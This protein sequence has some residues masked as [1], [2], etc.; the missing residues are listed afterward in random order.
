[1]LERL[2]QAA[3]I[4]FLLHLI[5]GLNAGNQIPPKS[6]SPLSEMPTPVLGSTIRLF[7]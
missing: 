2:I 1:M 3:L 5:A 6:V 4:T 7:K